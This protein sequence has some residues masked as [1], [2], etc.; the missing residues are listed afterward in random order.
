MD[1]D[2]PLELLAVRLFGRLH[3]AHAARLPEIHSLLEQD[4][5]AC[6]ANK[7]H[8]RDAI[9]DGLASALP[10]DGCGGIDVAHG[11][12]ALDSIATCYPCRAASEV[13][14]V[15]FEL[16][17]LDLN[18]LDD[19]S[20]CETPLRGHVD[21]L[22][23]P[24]EELGL[25]DILLGQLIAFPIPKALEVLLINALVAKVDD[26]AIDAEASLADDATI[27]EAT[28]A[29]SGSAEKLPVLGVLHHHPS[30]RRRHGLITQR[31]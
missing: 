28:L 10:R 11:C 19:G 27:P 25:E 1:Q 26:L 29:L 18:A 4:G 2:L 12:L 3:P 23:V 7:P 8:V 31:W 22:R 21:H 14:D 30:L 5:V 13:H 16:N 20:T 6:H 9:P 15:T 24:V 17:G